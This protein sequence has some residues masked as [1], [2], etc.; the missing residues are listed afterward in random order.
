MNDLF[1]KRKTIDGVKKLKKVSKSTILILEEA[2]KQG[3]SWEKIPYTDLFKLEFNGK[4]EYFHGQIPGK[5]SAFAYYCCKNKR[6][7]KNILEKAGIAV[8]KGYL[9]KHGD[10]KKY[11]LKLFKNLDKPLVVKPVDD[12]QGNGVYLNIKTEEEYIDALNKIYKAYGDKK[13]NILVEQMFFGNEYRVLVS[14]DKVLSIIKR[15]APNVV[16]DS[17]SSIQE[18]IEKK[19]L[20]PIR[21]K[22]A[23]YKEIEINDQLKSYL[24]QQDLDLDSVL[25]KDKRIF[26]RKHS[27][28]DVTLGG[29]TIDV[30]DKVHPSVKEIALKIVKSLPGLSLA[31]VDFMTKDIYQEQDNSTYRVIEV[32]SSPSLDWN[33]YPLVGPKREISFEFLKIIFPELEG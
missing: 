25:D 7:T 29:D 3:I 17:K 24:E 11:Y 10:K 27:S 8:S 15:L 6:V 26:L 32:N 18:L 21:K 19:N 28:A 13:I 30:T 31:G 23:T 12:L 14:Q 1:H 5:T 33:Q 20:D 2:D 22:V 9:I 4:T 16:G